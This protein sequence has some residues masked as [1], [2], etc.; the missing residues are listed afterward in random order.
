MSLTL[1]SSMGAAHIVKYYLIVE[2]S[3][4][5]LIAQTHRPATSV[6]T[7]ILYHVVSHIHCAIVYLNHITKVTLY[8]PQRTKAYRHVAAYRYQ[9]FHSHLLSKQILCHSVH[10]RRKLYHLL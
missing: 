3:T 2:Y 8:L 6:S 1:Q 4:M 10:L 9:I 5:N 7:Y